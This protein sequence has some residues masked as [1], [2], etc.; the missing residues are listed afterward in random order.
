MGLGAVKFGS[1][2]AVCFVT[3]GSRAPLLIRVSCAPDATS[4]PSLPPSDSRG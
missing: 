3:F 2:E 1:G 4:A